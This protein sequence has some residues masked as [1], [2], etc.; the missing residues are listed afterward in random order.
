MIASNAINWKPFSLLP[1]SLIGVLYDKFMNVKP[2]N[3]SFVIMPHLL[4]CCLTLFEDDSDDRLGNEDNMNV[5]E[6]FSHLI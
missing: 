1:H 2:N 4:C 3:L 6:N 5:Y